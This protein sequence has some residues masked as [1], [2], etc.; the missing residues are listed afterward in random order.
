MS[1]FEPTVGRTENPREWR[2]QYMAWRR[3][4]DPVF[5]E[6]QRQY[7]LQYL[8]R[9]GAKP[10]LDLSKLTDEERNIILEAKKIRARFRANEYRKA[11]QKEL[12]AKYM[13]RYRSDPEVRAKH[14][15]AM[16]RYHAKP[17]VKAHQA[18]YM[19]EYA[20]RRKALKEV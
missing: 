11:H 12:N 10:R 15:A 5:R 17:E 2:R 3:A 7:S 19:R 6:K 20:K 8:R 4:T 9:K 1:K 14:A 18:E 16:K 13:A